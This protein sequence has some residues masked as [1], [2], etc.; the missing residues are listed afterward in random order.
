MAS[1]C[2]TK[3]RRGRKFVEYT[4]GIYGDNMTVVRGNT[5][6]Y[7]GIEIYYSTPGEEIVYMDSYITEAVDG[8]P[9][10]TKNS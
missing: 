5:H 6:T 1:K 8:F 10:E 4:K 2:H 3:I 7:V 9:E